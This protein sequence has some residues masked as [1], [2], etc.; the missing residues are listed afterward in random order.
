MPR[1]QKTRILLCLA[2]AWTLPAAAL[3]AAGTSVLPEGTVLE[4]IDG[5]LV[6]ADGNDVWFFEFSDDVNDAGVTVPAGTRL[7]LLPCATLAQVIADANERL[8]PQYRIF[9]QVTHYRGNNFLLASYYLPL[10]RLKD[11]NEPVPDTLPTGRSDG[12]LA[13]PD[14]ALQ[15]LRSREPVGGPQRSG[16]AI[17]AVPTSRPTRMLVNLTGSIEPR[18]GRW[19]FIPDGLGWNVSTVRYELLPCSVLEQAQRTIAA[20]AIPIRFNVSGLV[21]DYRGTT[22]LILQRAVRVYNYGNFN[23]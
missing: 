15:L 19:C 1:R 21:T 13:I 6:R 12:E 2:C 16:A 11:A 20:T 18:Q 7:E 23:D 22:Y 8:Q 4:G 5:T 9:A 14:E 10:S 17:G 3:A